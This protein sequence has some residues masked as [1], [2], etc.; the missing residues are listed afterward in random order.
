MHA[1]VLPLL[2]GLL[3]NCRTA[4]VVNLLD[5]IQFAQAIKSSII[6]FNGIQSRF[7][8]LA[9]ITNVPQPVVDQP[10]RVILT[11]R[12]N[13]TASVVTTHDDV[14]NL[15]YGDGVLDP[16]QAVEIAVNN[17]VGDVAVHKHLTG[18]QPDHLVGWHPAVSTADPENLRGL[19]LGE[20]LKELGIPFGDA[21]RPSAI[22]FHQRGNFR[23]AVLSGNQTTK[24][25][26]RLSMRR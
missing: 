7:V 19:P 20:P 15:Q 18:I 6:V 2:P 1:Q 12:H 23:H 16:A 22:V 11:G 24:G 10:D 25:V 3:H 14:A 26:Y 5:H 17:H 13:T 8:H 4:D 21:F 9:N